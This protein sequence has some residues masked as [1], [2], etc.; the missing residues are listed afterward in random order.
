MPEIELMITKFPPYWLSN[1][2]VKCS[3]HLNFSWTDLIHQCIQI[4]SLT[5]VT[6]LV[7]GFWPICKWENWSCHPF[8]HFCQNKMC[9]NIMLQACKLSGDIFV[10][11][12]RKKEHEGKISKTW[13]RRIN[14]FLFLKLSH[15][16]IITCNAI[17][18]FRVVV[19]W[20][21][22]NCS[23]FTRRSQCFSQLPTSQYWLGPEVE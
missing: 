7:M 1:L 19:D 11:C 6:S 5:N 3:E 17:A 21:R 16:I 9:D 15:D 20:K 23:E 4:N 10:W 12:E 2:R 13:N 14:L 22:T 18:I 8:K